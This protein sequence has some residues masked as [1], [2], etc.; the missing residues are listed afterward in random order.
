MKLKNIFSFALLFVAALFMSCSD[1]DDKVAVTGLT[2]TKDGEA[3]ESLAMPLGESST[4]LGVN[5][6]GEWTVSV[7][8]ADTTWVSVTPHEGYGWNI[9]DST[10]SNYRSYFKVTTKKNV[11]GPRTT[12]L[13]VTA[14]GF[15]KVIAINQDGI[16]GENDGHESAWEMVENFVLGYNLGNTM[17]SNPY[18]SWWNPV[19]KTVADWETAWGQPQVTKATIQALKAKGFNVLRLPVTWYPHIA[20]FSKTYTK[21]E[22]YAIDADWMARVKEIVKMINDE[23]M[24]CIVNIQHDA[25]A[26]NGSG[27]PNSAWLHADDDYENV[28]KIYQA[29]WKQIATELKDCN[30]KVIFESFNEILNASS[31]WTAPNSATDVAYES[32]AKLQQDFVNVVRATGGN[33]EFRNLLITTYGDTGTS[34]V[35]VNALQVPTDSHKNHICATFHSYDPYWFCNGNRHHE[36]ESQATKKEIDENEKYYIYDFGDDQKAEISAIFNRVDKKCSALGIPYFFGEFGAI[37]DHPEMSE[38][39]K[40]ADFFTSKCNEYKTAGLWWMGLIDRNNNNTWL[41]DEAPIVDALVKN[42]VK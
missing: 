29:I 30:D 3:I 13:T 26:N 25:G 35:A 38:R 20:N 4:M 22:D 37:G 39:A 17:E 33:N 36:G 1:N 9:T 42:R 32:I 16:T 21:D 7:P 28:T 5:T 15:T 18:G 2:I 41:E 6:E 24:Y 8:D 11:E 40:Y 10:A 19:G 31:S 14:G 34:D 12:S 23:G 27:D